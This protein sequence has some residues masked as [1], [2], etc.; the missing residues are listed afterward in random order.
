MVE[1]VPPRLIR[2]KDPRYATVSKHLARSYCSTQSPVVVCL[3]NAFR[4]ID[5]MTPLRGY[6]PISKLTPKSLSLE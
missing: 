5:G 4:F 2:N 6:I 3:D 1:S